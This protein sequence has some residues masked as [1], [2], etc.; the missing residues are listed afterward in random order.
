MSKNRKAAPL[1]RRAR[2]GVQALALYAI[3]RHVRPVPIYEAL[4][5]QDDVHLP[6]RQQPRHALDQ[7]PIAEA[8]ARDLVTLPAETTVA[9]AE[10]QIHAHP[11]ASFPV[12][13]P[14][15]RFVGLVSEARLRRSL[16]EGM[17]EQPIG[18]LADRTTALRS[19]QPLIDAVVRMDQQ[20]T[21]QLAVVDRADPTRLVGLLTL[22]DI[23]RAQARI[24][25]DA[26]PGGRDAVAELSEVRETLTD[27]PAFRR[28]RPF[29]PDHSAAA[30]VTAELHYH[31]LVLPTDASAVG[32]A[33]RDLALP[34]GV[35]LVTIERGQQT[36]VPRGGT[37]LAANDRVTLFAPPQQ[38]PSAVATLTG[39]AIDSTPA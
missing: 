30:P 32:Q 18:P 21:R 1:V 10:Q 9:A 31:T 29:T 5:G 33:V 20:E 3:A 24:A 6:H 23:V 36:L 12:L 35:L 19:D 4:L 34:P 38:L 28:L 22:S 37:V 15:Q 13:G 14:G 11:Y 39:T 8:M 16:A 2:V 7:I 26:A 17:G 27:Q 25:R